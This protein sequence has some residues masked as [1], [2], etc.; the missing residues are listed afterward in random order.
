MPITPNRVMRAP[1]AEGA[2]GEPIWEVVE[3]YLRD[4]K[5]ITP[6]KL[7]QPRLVG[8]DDNPGMAS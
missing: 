2:T 6:R 4:Q 3:T 7:N 8:V 1:V 5:S